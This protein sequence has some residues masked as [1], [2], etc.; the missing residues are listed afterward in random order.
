MSRLIKKY[1]NRRLYDTEKSQYIT[2]E[3][4]HRY[5]MEGLPF[6][7]EDSSNGSDLTNTTLLQ[8]LVEM[9]AGQ[10]QFLS[11]EM[12][13]QLIALSNHPMKKMMQ[14]VMDEMV[15]SMEPP[16]KGNPYLTDYSQANEAWEKHMKQFVTQW[17]NFFEK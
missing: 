16:V 14:G 3:D 13:R 8:I 5:V 7:V 4:L 2:I 15:R 11:T 9:E 6:H 12:L 10:S 17:K 1:K